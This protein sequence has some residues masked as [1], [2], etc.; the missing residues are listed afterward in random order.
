MSALL[1]V[2]GFS[3]TF[4]RDETFSAVIA[5]QPLNTVWD[6]ILSR[7]GSMA[8]YYLMLHFW[9]RLGDGEVWLRLPSLLFA[10]ATIPVMALLARRLFDERIAL[11]AGLLTAVNAFLVQ[12]AREA[13]TYSLTMLLAV[14]SALLL[15]G[16]LD[17]GGARR[18]MLY[19]VSAVALVV[20]HPLA[21]L[22]LVAH[23]LSIPFLPRGSVRAPAWAVG[24]AIVVT[25]P[26]PAYVALAQGASTS[27]IQPTS[28]QQLGGFVTHYAGGHVPAL[29][30]TACAVLALW[31]LIPV[32]RRAGRSMTA[33]RTAFVVLWLGVPV[34]SLVAFSLYRPAFVDRYLVGVF[35]PLV[36]LV[37]VGL[38]SIR[39]RVRAAV[40]VSLVV[41]TSLVGVVM[42]IYL[43]PPPEDPRSAVATVAACAQ[44][45]D[46][47]VYSRA[48]ARVPFGYYLE[49]TSSGPQPEDVAIAPGG[50][51]VEVGDEFPVEVTSA[52]LERRIAAEDRLWVVD[53]PSD[54]WHP[55][56][57]PALELER[58]GVLD[59]WPV[60]Q[61]AEFG[62][63]R[64]RLLRA[65]EEVPACHGLKP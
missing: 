50:S 21:I 63:I 44:P 14:L 1:A 65:S 62:E 4:W 7:E 8:P 43:T 2:P 60:M 36:I 9:S 45:G 46:A 15:V 64:V 32:A 56:P 3:R 24:A 38:G 27:W 5:H 55:T 22:V 35:P 29:P 37:A 34:L 18:W 51:R 39:H 59:R 17:R 25:A 20:S 11:L 6:I 47:L 53:Y 31:R 12:Y 33:W 52:D 58:A 19:G 26:V 42:R 61:H 10:L 54:E 57:E 41:A 49:R 40:A 48:F 23:A 30:W 16:G 28:L 13:R